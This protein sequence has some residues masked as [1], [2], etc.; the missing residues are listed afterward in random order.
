MST[1]EPTYVL[2][3]G[4]LRERHV[5]R[6]RKPHRRAG[7]VW[8]CMSCSSYEHTHAEPELLPKRGGRRGGGQGAAAG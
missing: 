1:I 6:D 8:S 5:E 7:H 3:N 2:V 4:S